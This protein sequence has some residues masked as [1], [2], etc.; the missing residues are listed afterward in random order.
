MCMSFRDAVQFCRFSIS[1][2]IDLSIY[3]SIDLSI[4]PPVS[5]A[6]IARQKIE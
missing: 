6:T 3:R 1:I 4:C 2:S 5:P